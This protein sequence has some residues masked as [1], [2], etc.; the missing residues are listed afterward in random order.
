MLVQTCFEPQTYLRNLLIATGMH[1]VYTRIL[2]VE[3]CL[4]FTEQRS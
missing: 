1:L 3:R 2:C 4:T